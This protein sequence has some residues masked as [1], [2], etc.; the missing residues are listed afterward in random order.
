MQKV[1][2]LPLKTAKLKKVSKNTWWY[3][4]RATDNNSLEKIFKK[5]EEL[6]KNDIEIKI[7]KS[8]SEYYNPFIYGLL[9]LITLL[10]IVELRRIKNN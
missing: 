9:I 10:F 1:K 5:L 2:I 7:K 4:F 6:E 8:F 3:F